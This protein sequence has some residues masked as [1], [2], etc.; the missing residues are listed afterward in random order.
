VKS[1]EWLLLLLI[2]ISTILGGCWKEQNT[3]ETQLQVVATIYPLAEFAR[4]VGGEKVKVTQLLPVNAEPHH[5]EPSPRDLAKLQQSQIFIFNGAGL[6]PWVNHL[7]P[8]LRKKGIRIIEASKG[9]DLMT[10][11]E[12]EELGLL[13]YIGSI[14]K[15]PGREAPDPHIWLDPIFAKKIVLQIC[16][17]FQAVDPANAEYYDKRAKRYAS[18]LDQLHQQYSTTLSNLSNRDLVVTHAAFGYLARR[19]NLRQIPILGST[20]A[21]EPDAATLKEIINFCREHKVKTIFFESLVSPKAAKTIASE[22][23]A[24]TLVLNPI[25]GL[26]A[27]EEKQGTDYLQLMKRN[28]I[29]LK[30]GLGGEED[31]TSN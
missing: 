24:Q 18:N 1:R 8:S 19:Y 21:Q 11:A 26:T 31:D 27:E 3:E 30:K 23:G 13:F 10:F 17:E 29:N 6:E 22:I 7:L 28:L 12:E 9:L 2:I 20:P 25:G 14:K 5:W 16:E 4:Q 15:A